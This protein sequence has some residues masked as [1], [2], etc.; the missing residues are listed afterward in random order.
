MAGP[1]SLA[2]QTNKSTLKHKWKTHSPSHT[3]N[4]NFLETGLRTQALGKPCWDKNIT[5]L[6]AL[7][8]KGY[9]WGWLDAKEHHNQPRHLGP[10]EAAKPESEIGEFTP[11]CIVDLHAPTEPA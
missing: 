4:F 5:D 11:F 1:V 3:S 6:A 10:L 2:Q 8:F 9:A 7:P